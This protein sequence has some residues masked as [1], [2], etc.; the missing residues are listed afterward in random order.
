MK[1]L[2]Q[3]LPTFTNSGLKVLPGSAQCLVPKPLPCVMATFYFQVSNSVPFIYLSLHSKSP[4]NLAGKITTIF[5]ISGF[6]CSGIQAWLSPVTRMLHAE[7]S[8]VTQWSSAGEWACLEA[9]GWPH[10]CGY[11]HCLLSWKVGL[12]WDC[13]CSVYTWSLYP[14]GFRVMILLTQWP[15][16]PRESIPRHRMGKLPIS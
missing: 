7:L 16:V 2:F 4:L 5:I 15:R 1:N 13:A 6:Y 3:I 14:G 8:E 12:S 11:H 10:W 9:P